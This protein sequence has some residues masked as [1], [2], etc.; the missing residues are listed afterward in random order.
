MLNELYTELDKLVEKHQVYKVETIGDAYMVV[1]GAPHR[2]PAPLAAERVALFALEAV[3]FVRKF[4]TKDGNQVSGLC[5]SF[6]AVCSLDVADT[7]FAFILRS[8]SE[9]VW[10]L[11]QLSVA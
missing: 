10:L 6:L 1:G 9:P 2:I 7:L 4:R 5:I 8:L 11:A 3:N